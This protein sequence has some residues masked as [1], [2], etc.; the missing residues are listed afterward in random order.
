ML[1]IKNINVASAFQG[2]LVVFVALVVLEVGYVVQY[3]QTRQIVTENAY[4][5]V[6]DNIDMVEQDF[7][8]ITELVECAV[9]NNTWNAGVLATEP[10]SLWMLTRSIVDDNP[11]VYGSAVALVENYNIKKTGRFFSPYAFRDGDVIRSVQLGTDEYDYTHKEWFVRALEAG[12]KGYWSEPYYDEGGGDKLMTTY[13]V[14]IYDHKGTL[15]AVLTADVALDWVSDRLAAIEDYPYSLKM[16]ISK[17]GSIMATSP[18]FDSINRRNI[19]DLAEEMEDGADFREINRNMLAGEEGS[20]RASLQGKPYYVFFDKMQKTGWF[21]SMS[22]PEEEIFSELRAMNRKV[23]GIQLLGLIMLLVILWVTIR[24]QHRLMVVNENKSRLES[25]LQVA[26][27]I[28]KAMVPKVFPPF[29]GR[30]D[31]DIYASLTPAKEVGGDLYDYF[32]RDERLYFCIGD[33]SG[34]GVPASLVMSEACSFFRTIAGHEKSPARIVTSINRNLVEVNTN[35]MFVT[36]FCGVLDMATGHLRYC[37]AGHNAPVL[38]TPQSSAQLPVISNIPLG[39]MDGFHFQEQEMDLTAGEGIFLYT[40]GLNEAENADL[41]Q[42]GMDRAMKAM[43]QTLTATE[44]VEKML[45]RVHAFVGTAP[46][47]DDLTLLYFRYMNESPEAVTE[48][49]LVLHNDIQQIPR[50]AEFVEQVAQTAKLDSVLTNSL[51][52][53]LEEAVT[54]VMMYAYPA[55]TVGLVD[56]GVLIRRDQLEFS[57]VDSGK[58]FDPTAAPEADITLDVEDRPIGG[59]GIFL[60]RQIMDNVFYQRKEGRNVFTMQKNLL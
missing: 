42:F 19:I 30:K 47:S 36:F 56:I 5:R 43:D 23:L 8:R 39:V 27:D 60:V 13:S 52:L 46:Q 14:P 40:D 20:R 3:Y 34:K 59:L 54:N 15:A 55:G 22:I 57:I 25:E 6:Q 49:H 10:D 9:R 37:N 1:G 35:D 26:S 24:N 45:A 16:L 50:L 7:T 33:V 21:M 4:R 12:E 11:M 38:L 18:S 53:A 29:P 41:D 28:Q 32:I 44:Q 31:I 58:P 48:R 2:I 51:N 17:T